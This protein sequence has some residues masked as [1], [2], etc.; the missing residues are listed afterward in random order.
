MVT[1]F[2]EL[3]VNN[4]CDTLMEFYLHISFRLN[5]L[6]SVATASTKRPI[7]WWIQVNVDMRA[8]VTACNSAEVGGE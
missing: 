8:L 6:A 4:L 2:L 5:G 1:V 7:L 3:P